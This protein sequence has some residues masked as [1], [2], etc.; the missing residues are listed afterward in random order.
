MGETLAEAPEGGGDDEAPLEDV[1]ALGVREAALGLDMRLGVDETPAV[2]G[3]A[4]GVE[5]IPAAIDET[6]PLDGITPVEDGPPLDGII[7][8]DD[9]PPGIDDR[10]PM[11]GNEK[12]D[13]LVELAAC[14]LT[15]E[16]EGTIPSDGIS[17]AATAPGAYEVPFT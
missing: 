16:Y 12:L 17:T 10:R 14:E 3:G 11:E 2:Y 15:K 5:E 6:S 7:P 9:G 8:V 4:P 13:A 1:E